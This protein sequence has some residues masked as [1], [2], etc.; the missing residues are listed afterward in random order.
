MRPQPVKDYASVLDVLVQTGC[1]M[2]TFLRNSQAALLQ[3][4][5]DSGSVLCNFHGW[6]VAAVRDSASAAEVLLVFLD[7]LDPASRLVGEECWICSRLR[8]EENSVLID[9]TSPEHQD[10]IRTWLKTRGAFCAPHAAKVKRKAPLRMAALIDES[11]ARRRRE[12]RS[13]LAMLIS[14]S[15]PVLSEHTGLVGQVAEY[16]VSQRGLPI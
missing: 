11:N 2:C 4:G 5:T 9:L 10:R 6:G 3:D 8:Q 7:S 12:L 1:P 15:N 16:L 13:V 14:R